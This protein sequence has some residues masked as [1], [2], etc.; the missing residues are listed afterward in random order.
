ME[1]TNDHARIQRRV[2][3]RF[4]G[5]WGQANL[6]RICGWLMQELGDRCDPAS[7]MS[8]WA[9]R[10]GAVHPRNVNNGGQL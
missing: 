1:S 4:M 9:G 7:K 10:G 2:D 5:D 6:H 3:F 8:V